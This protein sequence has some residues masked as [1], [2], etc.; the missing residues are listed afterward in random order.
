MAAEK[1]AN[2][3]LMKAAQDLVQACLSEGKAAS[4]SLSRQVLDELKTIHSTMEK[5]KFH[6]CDRTIPGCKAIL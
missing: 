4:L 1:L 2:P 6:G 5:V 3:A